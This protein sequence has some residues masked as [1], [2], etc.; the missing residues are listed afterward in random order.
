MDKIIKVKPFGSQ[1]AKLLILKN[2]RG[3]TVSLS[4]FGARLVGITLPLED[5]ERQ[6]I[7]SYSS[8][9][10]YKEHDS[11]VGASIGPVAG[12]IRD[13]FVELS[14]K[15]YYLDQNDGQNTLHGG[16]NSYEVIYWDY[17][18][19]TVDNSVSFSHNFEEN[20]KGFP[21]KLWVMITYH[22]DE[23]DTLRITYEAKSTE[24][25]YFNPTN[26][27]YFNLTGHFNHSV[28][29]HLVKIASDYVAELGED[30]LPTGE[31]LPV[32]Y[33][34]FDFR[35]YQEFASGFHSRHPQVKMVGGYDHAW[36]LADYDVP[37][38]VKSPDK[39][40]CLTMTTDQPAV[41]IYTYNHGK[42]KEK[43]SA[44]S[45][46]AQ[47]VPNTVKEKQFGHILLEAN[48]L[49]SSQTTYHFDF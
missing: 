34:P 12:R 41:V 32:L 44:F 22:L 42:N 48:R 36:L 45:L 27:V 37:V 2:S 3:M 46:E 16:R 28:E 13:G 24:D 35:D 9:E 20:Y 17:F 6:V 15:N 18:I 43:H 23:D 29:H 1:R 31:L 8:D 25:T 49:Y 33:S 39:K 10:A 26:H 7:K 4:N 30:H 11:Y 19:N 47:A 5:G 38:Q 40:I 14:G 21:G